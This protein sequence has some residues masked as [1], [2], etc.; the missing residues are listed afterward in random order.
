VS[1]ALRPAAPADAPA[2]SRLAT[3]SFVAAFGQLYKPQDLQAFLNEYR[4]E[5]AYRRA[6]ADPAKRIQLAEADGALAAYCLIVFGQHFD[7]RP[8]PRP[9]NPV[10]ISQLYC[11]PGMN[12]RG[13]GAALMDWAIVEAR[14]AGADALQLSVFSENLGAQR[15]YRRYGFARA[16]DIDFWV[17]NHRD[18]EFLYELAL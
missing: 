11:A 16:A 4:T 12:G 7:E 8:E 10:F 15:F 3:D 5:A 6:L 18:H 17:G 13:L 2:L 9:V 14:A 1:I